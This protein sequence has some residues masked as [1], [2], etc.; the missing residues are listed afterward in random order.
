MNN[1]I[2]GLIIMM[3]IV[4][5]VYDESNRGMM[6]VMLCG[7]LIFYYGYCWGE[8][9]DVYPSANY[10]DV[11]Y[12]N[13]VL[14]INTDMLDVMNEEHKKWCKYVMMDCAPNKLGIYVEG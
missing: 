5:M 10:R 7:L 6:G 1:M 3:M 4:Y 12:K 11:V 9:Y 14:W 2:S 13:R 8:V